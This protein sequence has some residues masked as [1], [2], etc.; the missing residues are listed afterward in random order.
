MVSD[1]CGYDGQLKYAVYLL[2]TWAVLN[3]TKNTKARFFA[4]SD[5]SACLQVAQ[6]PIA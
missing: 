3:D 6:M 4:D 1:Q 2:C 5:R